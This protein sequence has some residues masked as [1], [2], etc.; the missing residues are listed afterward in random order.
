MLGHEVAYGSD[1]QHLYLRLDEH[2]HRLTVH[3][4]DHDDVDYVGWDVGTPENLQ[5][6][7][8]QVEAAGVAVKPATPEEAADRRVVDFA[9]FTD[10][11]SDVRMELHYGAESVF[12]PHY[13]PT[14]AIE[15]YKT[16]DQGLGHAVLFVPDPE[17][18][19]RFYEEVLGFGMSDWI[20]VPGMGRL[21]AFMHCNTRHHSLAFFANPQPR[22]KVHHVMM[23]HLAL[24]DVGS[25][26]DIALQRELVTVTLGRHLNDHMVSFYFKNPGDWHFEVGSGA[27]RDRPRDVA[28]GALQRAQP[29]RRRVGSRRNHERR[30]TEKFPGA[31]ATCAPAPML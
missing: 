27:A 13:H 11:N 7:A 24:D 31:R 14:R 19:A 28:G 6:V 5:A 12:M 9:Y 10:P 4:S 26:Y 25:G 18:A 3:P 2:H 1:D 17:A 30:V 15:G 8:A 22:K 21:G 16:G 23:E 29:R 20:I